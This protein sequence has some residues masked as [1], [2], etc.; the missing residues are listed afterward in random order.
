[1]LSLAFSLVSLSLDVEEARVND[2]ESSS[3]A[4]IQS[5]GATTLADHA[6]QVVSS[7]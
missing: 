3:R 1:M 5:D 6:R 4:W 7:S 2:D